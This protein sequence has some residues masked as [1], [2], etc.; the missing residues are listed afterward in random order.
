MPG[1]ELEFQKYMNEGHS[2][3][4][5]QDWSQA[6]GAYR[7]ALAEFPEN[8]KALTCLGLA[9]Y[10]TGHYKEALEKYKHAELFSPDD[11]LPL[12]KIA[13]LS[14]RLGYLKQAIEAALQSAELYM[15][16]QEVEKALENW[17]HITQLDPGNLTAHSRLALVNERLGRASQAVSEYLAVAS[18]Y[19]HEGNVDKAAEMVG[20]ALG[21]SPESSEARQAKTLLKE[22][23][24]L[25]K[26]IRRRGATGALRMA[27]VRQLETP[28][29]AE[30]RKDPV[31]EARGQA[32]NRM[33]ELLFELH[34]EKEETSRPQRSVQSFVRGTDPFSIKKTERAKVQ[35]HLGQAID[36]QSKDQIEQAAGELEYAIDAGINS[37]AIYYDLGFLQAKMGHLESALRHL[38]QAVKNSDYALG[39]HLLM[40]DIY[41]RMQRPKETACEYM[42]ALRQADALVVPPEYADSLRQLYD[43]L[44]EAQSG[45]DDPAQLSQL[46]ENIKALLLQ[47]N[48]RMLVEQARQQ[49]PQS[50][51]NAPPLP[52]AEI[53]T[54]T[55]SSDIIQ[56]INKVH[57][58]EKAG[59]LRSAIDTI[60][61]AL[62]FAPVYLPLHVLLGDLLIKDGRTQDAI[63]KYT[64]V[65]QAYNVRGEA[66]QAANLLRR[67][68]EIAPLD[69][70]ARTRLIDQLVAQEKMDEAINEYIRLADIYYQLTELDMAR[71]TFTNALRLAQQAGVKQEWSIQILGRMADIDMQRLDLKQALRIFEQIRT[72]KPED[73]SIRKELVGLHIRLDQ[74]NQAYVELD[75][76]LTY[77]ENNNRRGAAVPFLE[78]LA[79]ENPNQLG[80]QGYLADEY[81]RAGRTPEAVTRL[82]SLGE[83]FLQAGDKAGAIQTVEKIIALNPP[84]IT[85]Y[86]KLL[87]QLRT[88]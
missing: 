1:R 16:S 9:L 63:V 13:Q 75:N 4:W 34:G 19:Q 41:S 28:R 12:E 56:A 61:D 68:I 66:G 49:I 15:K 44:I 70:T 43:P 73:A 83:K 57:E 77:L 87:L 50:S 67:V 86:R 37:S 24:M 52:L 78:E 53:M 51:P 58:L 2:A 32:L 31:I 48:W 10:Q 62:K 42:E 21:L 5:D 55:K 36:A 6:V 39:S 81:V 64:V 8:P 72:L 71:K 38:Q 14:E 65:A 45:M 74:A 11:P 7:K 27:Q 35:Q 76:F 26:P 79:Q 54:Q 18:L 69:T 47:P 3:A 17:Q 85:E 23:Q 33:A 22:G 59:H 29:A 30:E 25:P 20:R 88:G 84:N 46:S 40:A 80:L 82:D 60:F